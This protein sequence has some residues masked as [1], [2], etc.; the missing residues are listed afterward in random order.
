MAKRTL[1][2]HIHVPL[3]SRTGAGLGTASFAGELAVDPAEIAPGSA[4]DIPAAVRVAGRAYERQISLPLDAVDD[5][6]TSVTIIDRPL[7]IAPTERREVELRRR[8]GEV[9]H[10]FSEV[11]PAFEKHR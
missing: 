10:A 7:Q 9:T 2:F 8:D 11:Y 1:P 5:R 3:V 6:T 4:V